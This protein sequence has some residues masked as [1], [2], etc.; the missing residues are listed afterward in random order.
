MSSSYRDRRRD[1][2]TVDASAADRAL[3]CHADGCPNLWVTIRDGERGL[4]SAHAWS[5][6]HLWPSVT[7]QQ[8]DAAVDRARR[9][10]VVKPPTVP[11]TAAE[12]RDVVTRM[13]NVLRN[14]PE[15]REWAHRLRER[16]KQGERLT[17]FQRDLW[18]SVL[19]EAA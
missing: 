12:K 5:S 8:Q 11:L 16:E 1:A 4:C 2:A 10:P 17:Q 14:R 3:M 15:P 6:P 18:R 19:K 7:Q 9:Q 13:R